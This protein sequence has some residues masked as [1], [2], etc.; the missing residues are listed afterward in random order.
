MTRTV[1]GS[2]TVRRQVVLA[3]AGL[4]A[5]AAA[6][7]LSGCGAGKLAQT[8]HMAPAVQGANADVRIDDQ[9]VS[10]RDAV[11]VYPGPK[12]YPAGG[13]AAL[14]VR[15]FN[16]TSKPVTLTRVTVSTDDRH[17]VGADRVIKETAGRPADVPS[18]APSAPSMSPSA[19]T[20]TAAPTGTVASG[21]AAPAGRP[22]ASPSTGAHASAKPSPSAV[23]PTQPS[24]APQEEPPSDQ[25]NITIGPWQYVD[26]TADSPTHLVL[27]GLTKPLT[28]G[29]TVLLRFEFDG[30]ATNPVE[31][32]VGPPAGPIEH[33]PIDGVVDDK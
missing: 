20:A 16:Q 12:G 29:D 30:G 2:K 15:V 4:T 1:A 8:A 6:G 11:V 28:G 24:A 7:L 21:S 18:A 32:P 3:A 10:V 19:A 23:A 5:V 13:Q 9:L 22:A 27:L 17:P 25:L 14:S 31:V 33:S 26:L